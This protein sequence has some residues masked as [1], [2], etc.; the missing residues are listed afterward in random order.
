VEL[1]ISAI[2]AEPLQYQWKKDGADITD[3]DCTGATTQILIIHT[4]SQDHQG[5]YTCIVSNS[6][7]TV[8]SDPAKLELSK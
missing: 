3:P 2:G 1:F 8:E 6:L 4:F 5:S 7:Q